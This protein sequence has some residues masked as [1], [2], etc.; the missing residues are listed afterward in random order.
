DL[1]A[2][3]TS[4]LENFGPVRSWVPKSPLYLVAL[5][6]SSRSRRVRLGWRWANAHASF[7]AWRLRSRS[8]RAV[9]Y[10]AGTGL[11]ALLWNEVFDGADCSAAATSKRLVA[12]AVLPA[13]SVAWTRNVWLPSSSEDAGRSQLSP[14]H[15]AKLGSPLSIE[16]PSVADGSDDAKVSVGWASAVVP[17]GPDSTVTSGGWVS[18]ENRRSAV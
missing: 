2:C 8:L 10:Q 4:W 9:M 11:G 16:H 3:R 5:P 15:G 1:S 12:S 7:R 18:T 6:K 17:L 14:E 13:G